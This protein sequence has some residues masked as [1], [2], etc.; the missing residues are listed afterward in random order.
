MRSSALFPSAQLYFVSECAAALLC[1]RVRSSSTLFPSP[2]LYF[3]SKS[4][5]LLCFRVR[6]STLFPSAQLCFVSE[7]AAL[8][9]FRVRSSALFPSAQLCFV[10]ECAAL[11]C[12]RV[13]SSTLFLSAQLYFV[14]EC[15]ALLC[16]IDFLWHFT[17]GQVIW[18]EEEFLFSTRKDV[19]PPGKMSKVPANSL[20]SFL[21]CFYGEFLNLD[22]TKRVH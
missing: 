11:L 21:I 6:S 4:A 7:C 19:H 12:F 14:S 3:V 15:A 9:C 10:S 1:F 8:L 18:I 5:A 16:G 2:Q 22:Y 17:H 13:R 20:T